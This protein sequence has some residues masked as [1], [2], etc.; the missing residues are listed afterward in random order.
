MK[1]LVMHFSQAFSFFFLVSKI[2]LPSLLVLKHFQYF[3]SFY[4][5][6]ILSIFAS[7]AVPKDPYKSEALMTFSKMSCF[8]ALSR[9]LVSYPTNI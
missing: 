3:P 8:P 4:V 5:T 9:G 7:E 2:P 6:N 1:T